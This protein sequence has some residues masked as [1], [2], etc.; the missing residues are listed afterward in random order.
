MKKVIFSMVLI[1]SMIATIGKS[2]PIGVGIGDQI[3]IG[4]G[5]QNGIGIGDQV[6]AIGLAVPIPPIGID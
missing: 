1:G 4:I 2:A 6:E 3:G 5:D